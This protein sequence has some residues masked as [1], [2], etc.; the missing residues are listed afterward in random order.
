M[1]NLTTSRYQGGDEKATY[2]PVSNRIPAFVALSQVFYF[3]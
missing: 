2:Q 3:Y 1:C